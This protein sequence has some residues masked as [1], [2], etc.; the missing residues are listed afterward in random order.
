MWCWPHVTSAR[1]SVELADEGADNVAES[2]T[3]LLPLELGLGPIA[4]QFGLRHAGREAWCDIRV[5]RHIIE[6]DG[7]VKYRKPI[8]GGVTEDPDRVL[9]KEKKRQDWV[10]GFKLG[11][12][13]FTWVDLLPMNWNASKRRLDREYQDTV[14]RFG[15]SIDDLAP[16]IVRRPRRR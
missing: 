7:R 4:T 3:R 11:M 6:F 14:A 1:A 16:Y 2:L 15:T 10:C 9:W 5:G 8:D 12:S 13:R